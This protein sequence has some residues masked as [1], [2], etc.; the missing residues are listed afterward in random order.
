MKAGLP[1]SLAFYTCFFGGS[2]N[3][4]RVVP[5]VPSTEHDCYYFTNY[6][7]LFQQ[8]SS[9]ATGLG[10][11][12]PVWSERPIH[13]DDVLD[14]SEVKELRCCPDRFSE[15]KKYAFVCWMDSKLMI[16]DMERFS[17]LIIA[18][19][20]EDTPC[21][22]MTRHPVPHQTVWGEYELA[23][24]YQKY[25][26][27]KEAYKKYIESQLAAG[28]DVNKALRVSCGFNVRRMGVRAY[29]IGECWLSHIRQCGIEDQIS[30]QFVH[31][32]FEDDIVLFPY[33]HCWKYC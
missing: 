18:V 5:P 9:A 26:R 23:I 31:Q 27:Q 25:A 21:M 7:P 28:M 11:W 3:W 10:R 6:M 19:E 8:L 1:K 20:R 24:T 33:Q 4:A 32:L 22:A 13:N 30:F 12:I 14:A 15:L 17:D 2:G 29:E 16:T